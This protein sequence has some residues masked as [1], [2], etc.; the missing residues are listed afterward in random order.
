[1][2]TANNCNC[3]FK[4]DWEDLAPSVQ[5]RFIKMEEYQNEANDNFSDINSK[6]N[7]IYN[8][9]S[10][11]QNSILKHENII[12]NI[13][14]A[15]IVNNI[16][17]LKTKIT[18]N[19]NK[20]NNLTNISNDILQDQKNIQS[21]ISNINQNYQ[22][23]NN[24]VSNLNNTVNT[25]NENY[26]NINNQVTNIQ[27][28]QEE[29]VEGLNGQVLKVNSSSKKMYAHDEIVF[30]DCVTNQ[31]ELEKA[32]TK[33][34]VSM[35]EIF[36]TWYRYAHFC[37]AAAQQLD[38]SNNTGIPDGQ[39]R[40]DNDQF[41]AYTDPTK[42][43]WTFDQS[44]DTIHNNYDYNVNAGFIN[45]EDKYSS[46]YLKVRAD[47]GWDDDHINI[48][49]GYMKDSSGVEHTLTLARGAGLINS[50]DTSLDTKF[51]WGLI[52]DANNPTQYFIT[53]L[54]SKTTPRS[55][56]GGS[57][58]ICYMTAIRS[59]T[60]MEFRTTDW[61]PNGDAK[62]DI[63]SLTFQFKYPDSKP[64][65]WS[66]AMYDNIGVIMKNPN[67]IGFGARST[68][69]WFRIEEQ[70]GI[71]SDQDI[72]DFENDVI[73][74][75]DFFNNKWVKRTSS[76]S[77]F[78]KPSEKFS[79][80]TFIYNERTQKL[81]YY[82]YKGRI[83]SLDT[84]PSLSND[85][86]SNNL[87]EEYNFGKALKNGMVYRADTINNTAYWED[88]FF[89][90]R[91]TSSSSDTT[92]EKDMGIDLSDVFNKWKRISSNGTVDGTDSSAHASIR[93]G[94]G[95]DKTYNMIYNKLNSDPASAFIS[96]DNYPNNWE[97]K[98]QITNNPNIFQGESPND[99]DALFIICGIFKDS[100][101]LYRDLSVVRIGGN[102][103]QWG[104]YQFFI[105]LDCMNDINAWS[106]LNRN[107]G[108]LAKL[109]VPKRIWGSNNC[110]LKVKKSDSTLEAWTSDI[111]TS[112]T[113]INS[114]YH[115]S[116]TL[117]SSKPSNLTDS[118]WTALNYCMTKE[119]QIG[120]G[121]ESNSGGFMIKSQKYI[122]EDEIISLEDDIV[123]KYV[124]GQWVEEGKVS[125][126]IP[127]RSLLYN[128]TTKRLFW[129]VGPGNYEEIKF[130]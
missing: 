34:P 76:D 110:F 109:S 22:N 100:S 69:G 82:Y 87:P 70:D 2:A 68:T 77:N 25:V 71:I 4:V 88:Y 61:D 98:I 19:E 20:I 66:Q 112:V 43:G 119:C 115:I 29:A 12:T 39:N 106:N 41:T 121:T 58:N 123:W 63:K 65:N 18:N 10:D 7:G 83:I 40:T 78:T 23:I 49:V 96:L 31:L 108:V 72:Y 101:G 116:Y 56:N 24:T 27:K 28:V 84:Q 122:F 57:H 3:R 55:A 30:V 94:Y 91:I 5:S 51:L 93:N 107:N 36:N 124:D 45:P 99:D 92:I 9:I 95:Y 11:I 62:T 14:D 67:R 126:T 89:I 90:K 60:L 79:D 1:M 35:E 129:Y 64:D 113:D 120:F 127:P 103:N 118:Q 47:T 32:M 13:V 104:D 48:I 102:D 125:N 130:N 50:G 8:D 54:S 37:S 21:D 53:D 33:K 85:T 42:G 15:D 46:F 97:I 117:P 38:N 111:D 114:N 6:I 17:T 128:K 75:Y 80:R 59:N 44:T 74:H 52:Y 86:A 105:M 73:Y 26:Q 81:Y 16:N